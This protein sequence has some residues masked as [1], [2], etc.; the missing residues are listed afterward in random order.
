MV[1]YCAPVD[2]VFKALADPGRR[3]LLDAL[4][5]RDGQSLAELCT[6]LSMTRFGTMKHIAVLERSGLVVTRRVGRK[7][8]HY[9][10]PVPIRLVHD[11]WTTKYA[12]HFTS[13]LSELKRHLEDAM[14]EKAPNH[15]YEV[16][17]RTTPQALWKAITDPS[18]TRKY[19][20][21]TAVDSTF[22]KGAPIRYLDDAE[23]MLDGEILEVDPQ[24]RLVT[25]F[26]M[27][28]DEEAKKDRPSRVTWTIEQRGDVCKLTLLHEFDN[29]SRTYRL[30]GPGWNPILSGLKTLLETGDPLVIGEPPKA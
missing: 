23:P 16:Y 21:G 26:V 18:F 6:V 5:R 15:V 25:T 14:S 9:L 3:A 13:T 1:T 7:K 19:Y 24:R 4:F 10:N 17:I 30:T 20:Y 12:A 11:R 8:L 27:L 22:E 29:E 28:N 2:D